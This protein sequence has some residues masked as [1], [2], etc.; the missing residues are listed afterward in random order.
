MEE[1]STRGALNLAD[2]V[3]Y[4]KQLCFL[5]SDTDAIKRHTE[6]PVISA[7]KVNFY[8]VGV[9]RGSSVPVLTQIHGKVAS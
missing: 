4:L 6:A 3:Y 2:D 1:M 7:S 5:F 8:D 9:I